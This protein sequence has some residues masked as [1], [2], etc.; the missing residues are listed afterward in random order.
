[1]FKA[2][3]SSGKITRE[4]TMKELEAGQLAEVIG[5]S[6]YEGKILMAIDLGG[7]NRHFLDLSRPTYTCR[8][9]DRVLSNG[10]TAHANLRVRL[11]EEG[12]EVI[13]TATSK[14]N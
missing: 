14:A 3:L 7:G 4:L 1:M 6:V 13:L 10:W 12:E 2:K 5:P 9:S 8:S 11:L